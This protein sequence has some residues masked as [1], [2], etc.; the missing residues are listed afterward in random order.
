LEKEK[1]FS[2]LFW[3]WA[4]TQLEAE[5]G[6]ASR[7]CLPHY[8]VAQPASLP[9]SRLQPSAAQRPAEAAPVSSHAGTRPRR[10]HPAPPTAGHRTDPVPAPGSPLSCAALVPALDSAPTPDF[11]PPHDNH[12]IQTEDLSPTRLIVKPSTNPQRTRYESSIRLEEI[13]GTLFRSCW[14]PWPTNRSNQ[15]P[16]R[17]LFPTI[18]AE[19]ASVPP[20]RYSKASRAEPLLGGESPDIISSAGDDPRA[21]APPEDAPT[22]VEDCPSRFRVASLPPSISAT[23]CGQNKFLSTSRSCR[24]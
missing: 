16:P 21:G 22:T 1:G 5:P 3:L 24:S 6:P 19:P 14:T 20:P 18:V 10:A 4:E 2:I 7:F 15:A 8:H 9:R 17:S 11:L 12:R 13:S 23:V